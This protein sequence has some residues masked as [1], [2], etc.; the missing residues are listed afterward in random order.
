M[1]KARAATVFATARAA[2]AALTCVI[3][4][5]LFQVVEKVAGEES[6]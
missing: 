5:V 3:H 4:G 2:A 6:S 1:E